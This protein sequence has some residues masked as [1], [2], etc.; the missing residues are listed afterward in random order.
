M[1]LYS[2]STATTLSN[3]Q[4]KQVTQHNDSF[5]C[6]SSFSLIF[7]IITPDSGLIFF[8]ILGLLGAIKLCESD[9]NYTQKN[10]CAILA[11]EY[12]L[13]HVSSYN[14]LHMCCS[15]NFTY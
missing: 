8:Q 11:Q 14:T 1:L 9:L 5:Q 7:G 3:K 13:N 12:M 10:K 4:Y 15:V 6:E 2:T